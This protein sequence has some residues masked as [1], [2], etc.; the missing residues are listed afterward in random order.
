MDILIMAILDIILLLTIVMLFKEFQAVAFDEE[1]TEITGV[2][3]T[4]IYLL[5][6][7]LVALSIIVLIRVVGII[8]VIALLT[9]PTIIVRQFTNNLRRLMFFSTLAAIVFT[10]FGLWLSYQFNLASGATI[11]L[12]LAAIFLVSSVVRKK[13]TSNQIK[14]T[15]Q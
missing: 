1:F 9:I 7:A 14:K 10:V 11:V 8:L 5:L 4:T 15:Q 13:M 2:P 6:L 3:S 12:V